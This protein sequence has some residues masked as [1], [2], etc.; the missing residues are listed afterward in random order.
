MPPPQLSLAE[1]YNV[2]SQ[3][4]IA[5]HH[6]FDRVLELCHR[7]IRTVAKH[8]G[9]NTFYEIPGMIIGYPLYSIHECMMYIV[10]ALRK[11]GFLVQILPPPNYAVIYM[12]W[13]PNDVRPPVKKLAAAAAATGSRSNNN[14]KLLES[15]GV[16]RKDGVLRLF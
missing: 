6:S 1:L 16:N 8:G 15:S 11:N 12:S 14:P 2:Q 7:R 9:M 3:K 4:K 10:D 5:R 13:E